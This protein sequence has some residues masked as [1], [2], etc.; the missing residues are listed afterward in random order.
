MSSINNPTD[1]AA[2]I[3]S[4]QKVKSPSERQAI[5]FNLEAN[6]LRALNF[7][8][9]LQ[10]E[11][12]ERH[13]FALE[14]YSCLLT[15]SI[16]LF[17]YVEEKEDSR[18]YCE[19]I[20]L[21]AAFKCAMTMGP[22]LEA[23][24]SEDIHQSLDPH[25]VERLKVVMDAFHSQIPVLNRCVVNDKFVA[26][27]QNDRT[28]ATWLPDEV[29][30]QFHL[31]FLFYFGFVANTLMCCYRQVNPEYNDIA[32]INDCQIAMIYPLFN[33]YKMHAFARC[34]VLGRAINQDHISLLQTWY[35]CGKSV[36]S[37]RYGRIKI[38][39]C[40]I[41]T[42]LEALEQWLKEGKYPDPLPI[43]DSRIVWLKIIG[44]FLSF[45]ICAYALGYFLN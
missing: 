4:Y 26:P 5:L 31:A 24:V 14:Q 1:I 42:S 35:K 21:D 28:G 43:P 10:N 44:V 17:N 2:V 16:T 19:E 32:K 8:G 38:T 25:Q 6:M 7:D 45:G 27:L 30:L 11:N 12:P 18:I 22:L 15:R 13:L 40:Y 37:N 23:F 36:S 9:G 20:V 34:L 33:N 39:E 3:A 29:P 41:K